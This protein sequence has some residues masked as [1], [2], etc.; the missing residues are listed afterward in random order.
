MLRPV[1]GHDLR[2]TVHVQGAV[3]FLGDVRDHRFDLIT[4]LNPGQPAELTR[5]ALGRLA[6]GAFYMTR[7]SAAEMTEMLSSSGTATGHY[8]A[9]LTANTFALAHLPGEVGVT[10]IAHGP[11]RIQAKRRGGRR[12]KQ[13]VTPLFSSRPRGAGN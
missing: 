12:A 5:L 7:H 10:L 4:D 8:E 13:G 11:Q 1:F 6:L 2:V 9:A 3:A